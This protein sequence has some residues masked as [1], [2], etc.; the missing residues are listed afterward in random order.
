MVP[1]GDSERGVPGP[2]PVPNPNK[3][4]NAMDCQRCDNVYISI[5]GITEQCLTTLCSELGPYII[6]YATPCDEVPLALSK[7][8]E[9]PK[10]HT[11]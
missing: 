10:W 4:L 9:H 2:L 5:R 11:D 3:L 1:L 7:T 6:G 8:L